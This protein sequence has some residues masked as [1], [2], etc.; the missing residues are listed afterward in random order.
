MNQTIF[1]VNGLPL[2]YFRKLISSLLKP[3][4][5]LP[6]IIGCQ[7]QFPQIYNY[8]KTFWKSEWTVHTIK[9]DFIKVTLYPIIVPYDHEASYY[10]D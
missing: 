5:L 1:E 10:K 9:P 4:L 3:N 8:R 7:P 6:N 2:F